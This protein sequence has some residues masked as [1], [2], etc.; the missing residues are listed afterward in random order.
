MSHESDPIQRVLARLEGGKR[1]GHGYL[2]RCPA[3][4]DHNPSLSGTEGDDGR[5]L[6][7]CH[8][9]R[10][11]KAIVKAIELDTRDLLPELAISER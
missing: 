8:A 6:L 10:E 4:D 2:A 9:G 5:V 3:H 11:L 7:K 1:N